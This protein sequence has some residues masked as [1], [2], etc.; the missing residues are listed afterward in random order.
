[1]KATASSSQRRTTLADFI[2]SSDNAKMLQA[3]AKAIIRI[4]PEAS[5]RKGF[6]KPSAE[7]IGIKAAEDLLARLGVASLRGDGWD[8]DPPRVRGDE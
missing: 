3:V 5:E 6:F 4:A 1:M 2:G 7:D 8:L